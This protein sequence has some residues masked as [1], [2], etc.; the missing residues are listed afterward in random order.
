MQGKTEQ[1]WIELPGLPLKIELLTW[2][3]EGCNSGR[4]KTGEEMGMWE[5]SVGAGGREDVQLG[6]KGRGCHPRV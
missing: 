4:K 6:E 3:R 1:H 5:Q 2:W